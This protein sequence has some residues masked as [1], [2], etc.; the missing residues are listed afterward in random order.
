MPEGGKVGNNMYAKGRVYVNFFKDEKSAE[1]STDKVLYARVSEAIKRT[2][3]QGKAVLDG[4][5]KAVYDYEHWIARFV[6]KARE[7]A[8]SLADKQSIILTQWNCR[9][10]YSA[11]NKRTYPYILIMDFDVNERT[12][13]TSDPVVEDEFMK[14]PDDI[15]DEGLPFN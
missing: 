9:N 14:I 4:S 11:E 5:G 12:G 10:P 3:K 13:E 8:E 6:G 1:K 15:G 2:D 7:K